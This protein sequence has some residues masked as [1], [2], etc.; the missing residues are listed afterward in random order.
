[1]RVVAALCSTIALMAIV[2]VCSA[3]LPMGRQPDGG[4]N[5]AYPVL[6]EVQPTIVVY[7]LT[8]SE[9]K[10]FGEEW[11]IQPRQIGRELAYN[12]LINYEEVDALNYSV[13]ISGFAAELPAGVNPEHIWVRQKA[14]LFMLLQLKK[15]A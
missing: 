11:G 2:V 8:P 14:D 6:G 12:L 7:S 9:V 10:A 15:E 5:G 13:P 1:M 3:A 4:F